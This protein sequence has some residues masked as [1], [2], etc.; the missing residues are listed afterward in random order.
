[1]AMQVERPS[2]DGELL[3]RL[4][5]GCDPKTILESDGLIGD[6]KKALAE[7][8]LDAEMDVH[9][10][11]EE[12]QAAGTTAMDTAGRRCSRRMARDAIDPARPAGGAVRDDDRGREGVARAVLVADVLDEQHEQDVVLVLAGSTPPRSSS[13]EAQREA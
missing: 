11:R 5:A 6:L 7:R 9:L 12:E 4:L 13:Q 1:M 3:D 2:I 8:M 10:G